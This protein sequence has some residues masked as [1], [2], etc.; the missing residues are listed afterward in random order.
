MGG[1]DK[2]D[3]LLSLY[4]NDQK[5]LKWYKRILFHLLDLCIVNAWLLYRVCIPGCEI[6]LADFKLDVARGLILHRAADVEYIAPTHGGKIHSAKGVNPDDRVDH[7][8]VRDKSLKNGQRCKN[9]ACTR[10]SMFMC[11]KCEVF[12]CVNCK[13]GDDEDCFYEFHHK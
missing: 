13:D 4:R 5:S 9:P 12:L 8:P 7:F 3:M 1:V 11:R 6:P 10:K 2:C